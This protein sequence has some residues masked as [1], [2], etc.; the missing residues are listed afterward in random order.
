MGMGT[1]DGST[2][3]RG[4]F[5]DW[6]GAYAEFRIE[7]EEIRDL[8]NGV[9]F[10]VIAQSARPAGSTGFV[11]IRYGSVTTWAGGLMT[12]VANYNDID[13]ARTAAEEL[14]VSRR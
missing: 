6:I 1:F 11:H 13:E 7:A 5:K 10:A 14:V 2:A 12:R 4:F 9:T 3:I 8:G